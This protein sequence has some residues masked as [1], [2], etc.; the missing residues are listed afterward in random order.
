[1]KKL[2]IG[3][4]FLSIM[5]TIGQAFE[6]G[7]YE[8]ESPYGTMTFILEDNSR[9]KQIFSGMTKRG[10]WLDR[11]NEAIVIKED[12]IIE[13]VGDKYIMPQDG[14]ISDYPCVKAQ[15]GQESKSIEN[16]SMQN[17]AMV[18][19]RIA[20]DN[21]TQEQ[22]DREQAKYDAQKYANDLPSYQMMAGMMPPDTLKQ[23][24]NSMFTYKFQQTKPEI[25]KMVIEELNNMGIKIPTIND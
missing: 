3:L 22:K 10:E 25:Q 12:I 5:T 24:A 20:Y 21:K 14:V 8:C 1:M 13:K 2:I 7:T 16:A 6:S 17:N 9:A 19:A 18:K 11:G 4:G 23:M 15:K